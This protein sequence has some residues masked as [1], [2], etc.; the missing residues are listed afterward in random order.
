[1]PYIDD[2]VAQA[3]ADLAET[4][5]KAYADGKVSAEET[6][7]IADAASKLQQAKDYAAL[8]DSKLKI[9]GTNLVS[10]SSYENGR[11][12]V[13]YG[14]PPSGTVTTDTIEYYHGGKSQKITFTRNNSV[15][16]CGFFTVVND[17]SF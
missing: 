14:T 12:I 11:V 10:D 4:T 13:P 3:R 2:S 5:A 9:A 1:M 15:D 7:A 16:S 6:R 17:T 8:L